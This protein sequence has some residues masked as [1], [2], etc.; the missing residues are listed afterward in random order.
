MRVMM[1]PKITGPGGN[2]YFDRLSSSLERHG[3]TVDE[4]WRRNSL[5]GYDI[6][7]MHFPTLVIRWASLGNALSDI[8][9]TLGYTQL[10][11]LRGARVVW[12]VH[13]LG[14]HER[15]NLWL[16]RIYDAAFA[17]CVDGVISLTEA[18]VPMIRQQFP[19]VR[20]L[21][22]DVVPHGHYRDE[23]PI[24]GLTRDEARAK[25]GIEAD[26][27][28]ILAF[29]QLR[30]YKAVERLIGTFRT[31]S[32]PSSRLLVVGKAPDAAYGKRVEAAAAGDDRVI[33]S[34]EKADDEK[35]ALLVTACDLVWAAYPPGTSLNSGVAFLALSLN[36]PVAVRDT[37]V[38]RELAHIVGDEWVQLVPEGGD[39]V[40]L[41]RAMDSPVRVD[42]STTPDLSV[43]DWEP[44]ARQTIEAYDRVLQRGR[45]KRF[46]TRFAR[47]MR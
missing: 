33:V 46:F 24:A 26:G 12:T 8:V 17:S 6:I 44:I 10:A 4:Y 36:R 23:Y 13:D 34:I 18:A 40:A 19:Q 21:P 35:A 16:Q 14:H 3:V 47:A 45:A 20:D 28:V 41:K 9:R 1:G 31:E 43:L 42:E 11:R 22:I 29:G 7:H 38:M 37:P 30:P 32:Q 27:P 15:V 2:P 5:D 39:E 25:L